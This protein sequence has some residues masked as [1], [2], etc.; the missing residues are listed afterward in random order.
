MWTLEL[1]VRPGTARPATLVA[2]RDLFALRLD[3]EGHLLA[4][5]RT[6]SGLVAARG[7]A[8]LAADR[9]T[10]VAVS[11]DPQQLHGLRLVVDG[12]AVSARIGHRVVPGGGTLEIGG[13]GFAG[14]IDELRLERGARSTAELA[15]HARALRRRRPLPRAP[16]RA[17]VEGRKRR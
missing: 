5:L 1:W 15:E 9:W 6:G 11:C 14:E 13:A 4:E 3:G 17:V 10:H 7:G 8:R 12:T 16:D 2:E